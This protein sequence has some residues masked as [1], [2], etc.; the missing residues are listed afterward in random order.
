MGDSLDF[1]GERVIPGLVD[2][3]LM[4]EHLARYRFSCQFTQDK[5][6]LD[7][8]CGSGYGAASL[9]ENSRQVVAIDL[10]EQAVAYAKSHFHR[11][12]IHFL[13]G[14]A[15]C[16]PFPDARFD[17]VVAFEI[18]EHIE[19]DAEFLREVKRIL[20]PEGLAILSTPNRVFSREQ[21]IAENPFH[22]REYSEKEFAELL[23][24][25]FP[26]I[27]LGRQNHA[28]G[29][30]FD[31]PGDQPDGHLAFDGEKS[32][33][34]VAN[35]QFLLALCSHGRIGH[36]GKNPYFFVSSQAD[37]LE[38]RN[39]HLK[40]YE[41]QVKGNLKRIG[42][43]EEELSAKSG[44]LARYEE[45]LGNSKQAY[46]ELRSDFEAKATHIA[47]CQSDLRRLEESLQQL[48]SDWLAK[49]EH[50][51][52]FEG[53]LKTAREQLEQFCRLAED[54]ARHID[55]RNRQL[56]ERI[57]ELEETRAQLRDAG[58][59]MREA[60][61]I[62]ESLDRSKLFRFIYRLPCLGNYLRKMR[63]PGAA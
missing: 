29:M 6:V 35:S 33:G 58:R 17:V 59:R 3:N 19:K 13:V 9:K 30:Q 15:T 46:D 34:T 32:E 36:I 27:V 61:S 52:L 40:L 63:Y 12:G 43:L 11:E 39:R 38:T 24:T 10:S 28:E 56:G 45:E 49:S 4:A 60:E 18:I 50:I 54:Q 23:G 44:H 53:E 41:S 7:L 55:E 31:F 5:S 42:E 51:R 20:K 1:S 8:A 22:I 14:D 2:P 21:E 25:F 47:L 37:I 16:L 48:R 57:Q 62:L 26:S